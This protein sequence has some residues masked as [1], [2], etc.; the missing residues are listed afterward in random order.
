MS[1]KNPSAVLIK[2]ST[3]GIYKRGSRYV[4]VTRHR[5]KQVKTFHRTLELAREAKGDRT[6]TNR[7]APL[8]RRA[9]DDCARE[10]VASCQGRTVRGFDEDTRKSYAAALEAHA[11]RHFGSMPMRD[12]ERKD[13]V[14]RTQSPVNTRDSEQPQTLH[15]TRNEGVPGSSPG[16]GSYESPA[17]FRF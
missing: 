4:V 2:T 7:Q 17:G 3:A 14:R 11:I 9:F 16:V 10:W 8:S 5:G 15:H 13:V 1:T 12:I 6:R